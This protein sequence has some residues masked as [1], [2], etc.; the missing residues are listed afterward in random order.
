[1][2]CFGVALTSPV[3]AGRDGALFIAQ[4]FTQSSP[5]EFS[6]IYQFNLLSSND[7]ISVVIAK[8][9]LHSGRKELHFHNDVARGVNGTSPARCGRE[10]NASKSCS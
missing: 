2:I 4:Y 10:K 3:L 7:C 9:I 5:L 6:E 1:M 8:D